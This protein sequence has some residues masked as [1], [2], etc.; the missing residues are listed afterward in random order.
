MN[1]TRRLENQTELE[2]KDTVTEKYSKN[3]NGWKWHQT[4]YRR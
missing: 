3:I 4:R 2:M 1:V